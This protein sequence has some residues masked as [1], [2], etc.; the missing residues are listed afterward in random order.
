MSFQLS[1]DVEVILART[2][3]RRSGEAIWQQNEFFGSVY[4]QGHFRRGCLYM[5]ITR[6]GHSVNSEALRKESV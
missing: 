2:L 6:S 4:A 3:A 5:V 1:Q